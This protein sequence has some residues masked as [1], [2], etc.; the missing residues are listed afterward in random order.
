MAKRVPED[1]ADWC[2]ESQKGWRNGVIVALVGAAIGLGLSFAFP[3]PGMVKLELALS[4]ATMA[5]LL[6]IRSL[7]ERPA[8]SSTSTGP[9]GGTFALSFGRWLRKNRL[10]VIVHDWISERVVPILFALLLLGLGWEIATRALF[11][12]LE[13][14]GQFCE[15]SVHG[16][17]QKQEKI[18]S[19]ERPFQ[20]DKLSS[21]GHPALC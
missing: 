3:T 20:T 19:S 9:I 2:R 18:G 14:S 13:A 12:V 15:G 1:D 17:A 16:E 11:D 7:G 21:A 4:V 5:A 6:L 8:S 10:L